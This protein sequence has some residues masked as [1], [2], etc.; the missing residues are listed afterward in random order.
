MTDKKVALFVLGKKSLAQREARTARARVLAVDNAILR[1][2]FAQSSSDCKKQTHR[3]VLGDV[4]GD[5]RQGQ[6]AG[7]SRLVPG[8]RLGWRP[9]RPLVGRLSVLGTLPQ[10]GSV[11]L[12]PQT[13]FLFKLHL[14]FIR[15][16]FCFKKLS[17]TYS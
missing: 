3:N 12:E 16:L 14:I 6:G 4:H 8:G 2:P 15:A 5:V 10:A 1:E 11:G 7:V 13:I 9:L 17:Q